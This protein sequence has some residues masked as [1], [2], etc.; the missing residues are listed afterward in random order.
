MFSEALPVTKIVFKS[1]KE[2]LL[3][4]LFLV[5]QSNLFELYD[6]YSHQQKIKTNNLREQKVFFKTIFSSKSNNPSLHIHLVT[7]MHPADTRNSISEICWCENQIT[8][9]FGF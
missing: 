1:L 4:N 6:E 5:Q 3:Q 9:L 7:S 2:K 8:D